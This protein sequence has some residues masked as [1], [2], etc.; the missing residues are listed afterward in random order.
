MNR[1]KFIAEK[2][3]AQNCQM[4]QD[5]LIH[6]ANSSPRATL[7][8]AQQKSQGAGG[9]GAGGAA[10]DAKNL[11]P[12]RGTPKVLFGPSAAKEM[13]ARAPAM[14]EGHNI[15]AQGGRDGTEMDVEVDVS[16]VGEEPVKGKAEAGGEG[17]GSSAAIS[18]ESDEVR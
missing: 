18:S 15:V 6:S 14:T 10:A 2:Q 13:K 16:G 9:G 1:V 8:I 5:G 11:S 3:F 12:S 7:K 4:A 17:G